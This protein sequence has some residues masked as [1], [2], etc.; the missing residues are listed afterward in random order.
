MCGLL[1]LATATSGW[2]S[3]FSRE[4]FGIDSGVVHPFI[5]V[6][7]E[8]TDN[9][10]ATNENEEDDYVSYVTPGFW[11]ALPG[12][13]AEVINFVTMSSAP[14][15]M[16]QTRFQN[17]DIGKFQTYF[18]YAPTFENYADFDERD[19]TSHQLDAYAAAN[20]AGGLSFELMDQYKDYRDAVEEETDSAEYNN[21]LLSLAT[22]YEITDK[23]KA[24]VDVG[25]Y[26]VNYNS[27]APEK[28]RVDT[29]FDGYL[30]FDVKSKTTLFGEVSHV[31]ID[32][33]SANRDSEEMKFFLGVK[34]NAT[35]RI[36]AMGK[37]GMM[38]KELDAMDD[39]KDDLALEGR[40]SYELTDRANLTATA[41]RAN[42]E[43]TTGSSYFVT[44]TK[45]SLTGSYF[46][47]DRISASLMVSLTDEE[48]DSIDRVDTT[49]LASPRLAYTFNNYIFAS[50]SYSYSDRD[51]DG[52]DVTDASAYTENSVLVSVTCSL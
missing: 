18:K 20:F 34:Y 5:T 39:T 41:S 4:K 14:G 6:D 43:T 25:Y 23:M 52:D 22:S 45:G 15:G 37:I 30:F 36:D 12:S 11:L 3:L 46:L 32:Y 40:L 44:E 19:F 16:A 24:R 50:L 33:D 8:Y 21:N 2:C 48:Y 38:R 10:F 29:S 42:I 26:D 13:D 31:D 1:I 47:T 51:V 17:D 27:Q 35:D 9:L 7:G 28:D 49:V